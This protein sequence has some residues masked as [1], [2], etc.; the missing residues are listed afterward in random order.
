[1]IA[2]GENIETFEQQFKTL[3]IKTPFVGMTIF[4]DFFFRVRKDEGEVFDHV[5]KMK[6][7]PILHA[8]KGRLND[9]GESIA[10]LSSG[11]LAPLAEM[12]IGY[13]ELYCSAKIQYFKKDIIFHLVG[14]KKDKIAITPPIDN[15]TFSLYRDLITTK[16]KKVYNATI[17]LARHLF[18]SKG[19]RSGIIYSSAQEDKSNQNLFNLAIRPSDFDECCR[20]IELEYNILRYVPDKDHILIDNINKGKPDQTGLIKWELSYTDMIEQLNRKIDGEIFKVNNGI[21]HY[22]FGGGHIE[23]ETNVSLFVRFTQTND[24]VEIRKSD[25]KNL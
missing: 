20:I 11:E 14:V 4:N 10:Y 6:Y 19:F 15:E 24:I 2:S 25:V 3:S 9:T 21:V 16:D 8:K 13:Y 18:S 17:A 1:M 23:N 22:K 7:P 5:S 12:D